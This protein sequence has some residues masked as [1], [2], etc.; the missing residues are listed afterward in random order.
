MCAKVLGESGSG[1]QDDYETLK[2]GVLIIYGTYLIPC[3]LGEGPFPVSAT[4]GH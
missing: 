4:Y 1:V 2:S 3:N